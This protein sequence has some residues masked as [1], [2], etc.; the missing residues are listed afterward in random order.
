MRSLI[1]SMPWLI[2][3]TT[4]KGQTVTCC[5]QKQNQSQPQTAANIS[6][7][8]LR[9]ISGSASLSTAQWCPGPLLDIRLSPEPPIQ[10]QAEARSW[11]V[12]LRKRSI[13]WLS[14][15]VSHLQG[16][17]VENG[18]HGALAAGLPIGRQQLQ[19]LIVPVNSTLPSEAANITTR[20]SLFKSTHPETKPQA[21][22]VPLK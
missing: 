19:L 11:G 4:R 10:S 16:D 5:A 15:R 1:W 20:A 17:D 3:S 14:Q 8:P 18:A 7:S 2:S 22:I 12:Q 9:R 6:I 13:G 21:S